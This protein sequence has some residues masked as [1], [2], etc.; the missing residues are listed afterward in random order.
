MPRAWIAT[1]NPMLEFDTPRL[2]MRRLSRCIERLVAKPMSAADAM[3]ATIAAPLVGATTAAGGGTTAAGRAPRGALK[4]GRNA[5]HGGDAASS[6]L[7]W[8]AAA[9]MTLVP[10]GPS[11]ARPRPAPAI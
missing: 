6:I 5:S 9:L 8:L 7:G 11:L 4:R 2:C 3:K 10:P 1:L